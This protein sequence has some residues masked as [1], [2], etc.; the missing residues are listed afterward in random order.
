MN[1]FV[2]VWTLLPLA[3]YFIL[4]GIFQLRN[5]VTVLPGFVDTLLLGT[6]LAGLITIGPF[7]L[8]LPTTATNRFGWFAHVLA[9]VLYG[10]V[11]VLLSLSRK[12]RIVV[13]NASSRE[14]RPAISS[15]LAST[16]PDASLIGNSGGISSQGI[17]FTLDV[18][19][20]NRTAQLIAGSRNIDA[21]HWSQF[22]RNLRSTLLGIEVGRNSRALWLVCLG[23]AA[24]MLTAY[25]S[26]TQ[27]P[28]LAQDFQNWLQR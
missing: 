7:E 21:R 11:V 19:D 17:D 22:R 3:A 28:T 23:I 18:N 12:P 24:M 4:I 10:L 2:A 5:R 9:L 6:G 14:L 27:W 15:V 1:L 26:V 20:G 13:Y 8:F 25:F 16:D